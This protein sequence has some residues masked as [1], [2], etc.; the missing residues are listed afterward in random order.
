MPAFTATILHARADKEE[1]WCLRFRNS[2]GEH[3]KASLSLD[4]L[5]GSLR[6][7]VAA[8]VERTE[9]VV[10]WFDET[11]PSTTARPIA[12]WLATDAAPSDEELSKRREARLAGIRAARNEVQAAAASVEHARALA[13]RRAEDARM[14]ERSDL[15]VRQDRFLNPYAYVGIEDRANVSGELSD[16]PPPLQDRWYPDRWSGRICFSITVKTPLLVLDEGRQM[17]GAPPGHKVYGALAHNGK[18]VLPGS[19]LRG[20][21][22]AH[23]EAITNSR[24]RVFDVTKEAPWRR[25]DVS[26][27]QGMVPARIVRGG[28]AVE[29][30]RGMNDGSVC[31]AWLPYYLR[32]G[33]GVTLQG[34]PSHGVEVVAEIHAHEKLLPNGASV[35]YWRVHKSVIVGQAGVEAA[36]RQLQGMRNP[37]YLRE[38]PLAPPADNRRPCHVRKDVVEVVHGWVVVSG[39][40]ASNKH[41]ERVF[42]S[43]Q[44][45]QTAPLTAE[46]RNTWKGVLDSY[47]RDG[48]QY[49]NLQASL[50]VR[51]GYLDAVEANDFRDVQ[52]CYAELRGGQVIRLLPVPIARAQYES[53]P[54]A[55]LPKSLHPPRTR[56]ESSPA[57][58]VFGFVGKDGAS[59]RSALRIH[60]VDAEGARVED[61]SAHPVALATLGEPKN[62]GRFSLVQRGGQDV[63]PLAP[64]LMRRQFYSEGSGQ[65]LAGRKFYWTHRDLPDGYWS[66]VD[67]G[68]LPT[69]RFREF[70][71]AGR[72]E[73]RRTKFNRSISS[74]IAPDSRFDVSLDVMN[75][76]GAELGA[77]L[78]LLDDTD[79]QSV[80]RSIGYGK[81]LGFGST[82][83]QLDPSRSTLQKGSERVSHYA[84]LAA[85][86]PA[87]GSA[88]S[89]DVVDTLIGE[90]RRAAKVAWGVSEIEAAPHVADYLA[91]ARGV[92][93]LAVRYPRRD[94]E[95]KAEN[96]EFAWFMAN[97]RNHNRN[98]LE[99]PSAETA[100]L[101]H[102]P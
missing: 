17:A 55:L 68:E 86:A 2:L 79:K 3:K 47:K 90:F 58:R 18:P 19:V 64:G 42:F 83:W 101:P 102:V 34:V 6:D 45:P 92:S 51:A 72:G 4:A 5:H 99:R 97:E 38:H 46:L 8:A 27:G 74:W 7:G 43:R 78:W 75:L 61:L 13:A 77:L 96:E 82:Q 69:G 12:V 65:R 95:P 93:G 26:E 85:P 57:D 50:H 36:K 33:V 24:L 1:A 88:L 21:L 44:E 32:R 49:Q 56:S 16:A 63:Q 29:L 10:A 37:P 73:E 31:A 91:M 40:N 71:H 62:Y 67:T 81:P 59:W 30:F 89:R 100:G 87:L 98:T 60:A 70:E 23:F 41:D 84:D 15:P 35:R 76:S 53:A 25:M 9:P 11:A 80:F 94:R 14:A 39:A 66:G 28:Q 54:K 48:G 20:A 52:Y 22:S